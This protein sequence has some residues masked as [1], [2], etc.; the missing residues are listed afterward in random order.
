M[1]IAN[2]VKAYVQ[3]ENAYFEFNQT[4]AAVYVKVGTVVLRPCM[5]KDGKHDTGI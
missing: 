2:T 3:S 1:Q 4:E 5:Q